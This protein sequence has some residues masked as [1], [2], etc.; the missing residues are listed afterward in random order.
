MLGSSLGMTTAST[1]LSEACKQQVHLLLYVLLP[2]HKRPVMT[3]TLL[4]CG[5]LAGTAAKLVVDNPSAHSCCTIWRASWLVA[6]GGAHL[7]VGHLG[8]ACQG[9]WGCLLVGARQ[10][11]LQAG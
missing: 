4:W 8:R 11:V 7:T 3:Q 10:R 9:H 1:L 5:K 2:H 6:S